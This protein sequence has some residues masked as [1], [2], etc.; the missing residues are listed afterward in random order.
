MWQLLS[1][2]GILFRTCEGLIDIA[3]DYVVMQSH[4]VTCSFTVNTSTCQPYPH[5]KIIP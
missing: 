2:D 5:F 3:F 1:C 4:T